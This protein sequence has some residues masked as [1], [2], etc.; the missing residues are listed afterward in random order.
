LTGGPNVNRLTTLG[1]PSSFFEGGAFDSP[2]A[3]GDTL[4][5][6]SRIQDYLLDTGKV[7]EEESPE[8][9]TSDWRFGMTTCIAAIAWNLLTRE[10]FIVTASDMRVSFG[11]DFSA[12]EVVKLE[13]F[14]KE[15]AAL[16]AGSDIS[17]STSVIE[18]AKKI[19]KG[20][21]NALAV[22]QDGFKKAYQEQLRE[23]ITDKFLSQ[24]DMS[25][26][27]FKKKG[28]RQLE[29]N[30][31][32]SLSFGIRN[33][34][35]GCKFL[36]YGFDGEGRAHLFEVS[37]P[38]KIQSKDKPGFWAI[39]NGAVSAL[40]TL[41]TLK[42]ASERSSLNDTIYN[43]LAAKYT[44]ESA[45]DV[46]PDTFLFV[47]K[48]G[49]IGFRWKLNFEKELREAWESEGRP[50]MPLKAKQILENAQIGFI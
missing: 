5:F 20:K 36:I 22:I 15:W 35:L 49:S 27:D 12:E 3:F 32:Q 24:F 31:F 2:L 30:L 42:Q 41:A 17:Q 29:P 40:S 7:T 19:V 8:P 16:I 38:G 34:K 50:K 1:A 4:P 10:S 28:R 23:V 14:H 47:K 33:E 45:S 11:G 25:L 6:R 13:G 37:E 26:D 9:K 18:R 21:K 43:V 46:G 39:G 44:S 48:K